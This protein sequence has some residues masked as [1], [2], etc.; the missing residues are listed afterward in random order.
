MQISVVPNEVFHLT[1]FAFYI[2]CCV[3]KF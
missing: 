3:L 2:V 1:I